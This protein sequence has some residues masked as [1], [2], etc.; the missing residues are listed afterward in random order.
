[1]RG[2][3]CERQVLLLYI[4]CH[5][6]ETPLQLSPVLPLSV[7]SVTITVVYRCRGGMCHLAPAVPQRRAPGPQVVETRY[8]DLPATPRANAQTTS[9]QPSP[10]C[11]AYSSS[12]S[13]G[14]RAGE[15]SQPSQFP[16][17]TSI[18]APCSSCSLCCRPCCFRLSNASW[19]K[20]AGEM[21]KH[22]EAHL[23][24]W[25]CCSMHS[26]VTSLAAGFA[27]SVTRCATRMVAA[28]PEDMLLV[29]TAG[30]SPRP[31]RCVVCRRGQASDLCRHETAIH[32]LS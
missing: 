30:N 19:Q 18:A 14:S 6:H 10:F 8:L 7:S 12:S 13:G 29:L 15:L 28:M 32:M 3:G 25:A 20:S 9:G 16:A 21:L 31:S 4:S 26:M 17:V 1:M 2:R 22:S 27:Q 5:D 24:C 23:P 11:Q